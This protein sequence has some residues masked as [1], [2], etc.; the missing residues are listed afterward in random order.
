MAC[1]K[2]MKFVARI[3]WIALY[4][5]VVLAHLFAQLRNHHRLRIELKSLESICCVRSSTLA[6]RYLV[7]AKGHDKRDIAIEQAF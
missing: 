4:S 1:Q 6:F 7:T 3:E 5:H 2:N